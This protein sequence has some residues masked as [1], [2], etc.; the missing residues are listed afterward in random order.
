MSTCKRFE[1][2]FADGGQQA[3][4]GDDMRAHVDE[5]T[6]CAALAQ[7]LGDV[8]NALEKLPEVD[9]PEETR[10]KIID[11]TRRPGPTLVAS[12]QNP[13][14][15]GGPKALRACVVQGGKV[16]EER[17]LR[18]RESLS[19]GWGP[20]N[21]FVVADDKLPKTHELFAHRGGRYQ[22]VVTEA[23]RGR[24]SVD[25][26]P[27]DFAGLKLQG[28]M[29]K[30]GATYRLPLTDRHRGK[31]VIGDV[32][33]IFQFVVPPPAA[34]RPRLPAA[35]RGNIW[36]RIDWPYAAALL[37]VFALEAPMVVYFEIM[38]KPA[39]L[40]L[41]DIDE[42]WANLIVPEL[43]K[44]SEVEKPKDVQGAAA[45]RRKAAKQKAEEPKDEAGRAKARAARKADIDKS[46]AGKGVLAILGTTG[47]GAATGA[48][49]DVFGDGGIGGDLD[50]AFDGISGVGLATGDA[51]TTRGGGSGDAATIGGLATA[52]GGK[53]GLGG[54]KRETRLG[55]VAT[56]T[57][58]VDGA[59]DSDAIAKVVRSRKRMVQDCYE[60]ELKR[61]PTLAGKIEIEFTIGS[62]GRVDEALV[63]SN[64]MGSDAVGDCIVSRL[65]RWRFPKPDGGSVTV[66][67]PFIFT[68]SS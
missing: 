55:S 35:A 23:M 54:G 56:A 68:P 52:G 7:A 50:A 33:V 26:A 27:V 36:Q 38:P 11:K 12:N 65:K 60:R 46:I 13:R 25:G 8:D 34:V 64:R 58:E 16:I 42:R 44:K 66:S 18:R 29:T 30:K 43:E 62:S 49:A 19:V 57:P 17:R 20:K 21:S 31:V 48:V 3:V 51:R 61:D 32:T 1:R 67:F 22:L 63:A 9:M 41:D 10:Q 37:T 47:D 40:S 59:L 5:C 4:A 15:L 53:V 39:A 45:E 2:A 14:S 6:D 24:V 28:S